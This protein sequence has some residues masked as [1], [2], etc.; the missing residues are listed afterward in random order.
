M[1]FPFSVALLQVQGLLQI[2]QVVSIV[3]TLE[4]NEVETAIVSFLKSNNLEISDIDALVLGFDGNTNFENYYKN[5]A[6][7][8]DQARMS[9]YDKMNVD[10]FADGTGN[11]SKALQRIG[12]NMV[13]C[14]R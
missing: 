5:L 6:E 13:F 3:N 9:L 1:A 14:P 7:N 12:F 4:E 11:S 10:A 2:H 8:E